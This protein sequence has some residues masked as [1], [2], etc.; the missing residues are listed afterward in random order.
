MSLNP[1]LK[2]SA[3]C[4]SLRISS[5]RF[6]PWINPIASPPQPVCF[7]LLSCSP[8]SLPSSISICQPQP[9]SNLVGS[10]TPFYL[11]HTTLLPTTVPFPDSLM[12]PLLSVPL[13]SYFNS[14]LEP[15]LL[16]ARKVPLW[17]HLH[18]LS[19]LSAYPLPIPYPI[20]SRSSSEAFDHCTQITPIPPTSL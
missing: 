12:A 3:L 10:L 6:S 2:D 19:C 7:P 13:H 16:L 4:I 20:A 11:D 17:L 1:N 15:I 18:L 14:G 8:P 5:S 9:R